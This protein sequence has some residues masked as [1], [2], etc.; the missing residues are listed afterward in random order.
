MMH[1]FR[2]LYFR[3][4]LFFERLNW[5]DSEGAAS[6]VISASIVF[7]NVVVTMLYIKIASPA[8]RYDFIYFS[9]PLLFI[10][11]IAAIV[12]GFEW[13]SKRIF[14]NPDDYRFKKRSLN[15][16]IPVLFFFA[17]LILM[18]LIPFIRQ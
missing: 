15:T 10:A 16:I 9:F 7:W 18:F 17:P 5:R 1:F 12:P 13:F 4:Y 11:I 8:H 2:I 14:E 3:Y 6:Q